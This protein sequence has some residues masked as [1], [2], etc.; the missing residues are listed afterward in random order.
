MEH[1]VSLVLFNR[2]LVF[3]LYIVVNLCFITRHTN[4]FSQPHSKSGDHYQNNLEWC[5]KWSK[6][7]FIQKSC[8][9][10]FHQRFQ[11]TYFYKLCEV[12]FGNHNESMPSPSHWQC[13]NKSIPHFSKGPK[14]GM[15]CR[16]PL[17]VNLCT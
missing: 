5:P 14:G 15:G 10:L 8:Y 12:V 13:P 17:I 7:L 3:G 16:G 1:D 6:D 4:K 9:F 2:P 11:S